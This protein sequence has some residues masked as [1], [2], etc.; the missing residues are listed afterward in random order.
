[1]QKCSA[2]T[3]R[4]AA[5][6]PPVWKSFLA[7]SQEA[8]F[9]TVCLDRR[10]PTEAASPAHVRYILPCPLDSTLHRLDKFR[11]LWVQEKYGQ[12]KVRSVCVKGGNRLSILFP[13]FLVG[14]TRLFSKIKKE[15][16]KKGVVSLAILFFFRLSLKHE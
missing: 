9:G 16:E 14:K 15:K 7:S 11:A 8:T 13:T 2:Q 6:N 4:R 3:S 1:M 12:T 5:F 10:S